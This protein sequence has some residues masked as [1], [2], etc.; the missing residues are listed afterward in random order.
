[1]HDG[2]A[3][4]SRQERFRQQPHEIVALDED[5]TVIKKETAVE[6][7]VPGN[8]EVSTVFANSRDW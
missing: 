3:G 5:P 7:S 1:V 2:L 4:V 6:V 8:A